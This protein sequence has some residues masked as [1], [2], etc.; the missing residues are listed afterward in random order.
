M[1]TFKEL[2]VFQFLFFPQTLFK[3]CIL[4]WG[5]LSGG[6]EGT[7]Q[8]LHMCPFSPRPSSH[9]GCHT[10]LSRATLFFFLTN[11]FGG[12]VLC[13][14]Q[15]LSSPS[16]LEANSSAVKVWSPNFW[17]TREFPKRRGLLKA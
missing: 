9:P 7:R 17:T 16:G 5:I 2:F 4:S 1:H 3:F 12:T 6:K 13:C 14:L 11:F 10:T 8:Y 15:N